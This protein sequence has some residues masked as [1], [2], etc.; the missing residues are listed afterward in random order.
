GYKD[1]FHPDT[2]DKWR[3]I[4]KQTQSHGQRLI[5]VPN[6]GRSNRLKYG[7]DTKKYSCSIGSQNMYYQ[8]DALSEAANNDFG[9]FIVEA[10]NKWTPHYITYNSTDMLLDQ[11]EDNFLLG[12]S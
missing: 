10:S 12:L 8:K 2:F 1:I 11:G 4:S 3:F 5:S 7:G 9:C 6:F